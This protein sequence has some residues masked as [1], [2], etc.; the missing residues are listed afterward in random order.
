VLADLRPEL[1]LAVAEELG[2]RAVDADA[3]YDE[4]V[5]VFAPCGLGSVLDAEAVAR[6]RCKVVAGSANTQLASAEEARALADRGVLFAPDFVINVGGALAAVYGAS[7]AALDP[8]LEKIGQRLDE[9][10][11]RAELEGTT[12]LEAAERLARERMALFL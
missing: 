7:D 2:G 9:V 12:P 10:F 11:E 8:E 4:E 5:D 6:L 3:I 1:S